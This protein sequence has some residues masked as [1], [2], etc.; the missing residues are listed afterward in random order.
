MQDAQRT[1]RVL[2][3]K[4]EYKPTEDGK[5]REVHWVQ[6]AP[7]HAPLTNSTWHRIKDICPPDEGLKNDPQGRGMKDLM[8]RWM[9]IEPAYN[10]WK[11]GQELPEQGT[12][13]ASWP[14]LTPEQVKIFHQSGVRSV[15]EVAS[16]PDNV[17]SKVGLPDMRSIVK[18]AKLFLESS[19][20][21][22]T[23]QKLETQQAEIDDLKEKLAAAMELL[24]E[25]TKP[26]R[27]GR[28]A[29][30]ADESEAA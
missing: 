26:K 8:F 23:A 13:L 5:H 16:L 27:G 14:V 6:I 19:D 30:Q 9:Q 2:G 10:A 21:A 25:H 28:K 22:V 12:A 20:Q 1:L 17:A 24:E 4:K 15:E 11:A 29:T 7:L 3:F 18:Q